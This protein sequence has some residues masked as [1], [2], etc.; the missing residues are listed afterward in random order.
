MHNSLPSLSASS[1]Q[2]KLLARNHRGFRTLRRILLPTHGARVRAVG[3]LVAVLSTR[4]DLRDAVLSRTCAR[5][6]RVGVFRAG[7]EELALFRC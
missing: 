7:G 1:L 3:A 6:C 4:L 2:C 5:V